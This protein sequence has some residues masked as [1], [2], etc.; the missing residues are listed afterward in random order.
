MR[1]F[2]VIRRL[3]AATLAAAALL[4]WGPTAAA[5]VVVQVMS[6]NNPASAQAEAERLLSFGVPSFQRTENVPDAGLR[7]RVY[8]GPFDTRQEA[9]A[10]AEALKA[11]G[12]VTDYIIREDAGNF[13]APPPPEA[14]PPQ[15]GWSNQ[16]PA[17]A[18]APV[19]AQP[20]AQGDWPAQA[21]GEWPAYPAQPPAQAG[22]QAQGGWPPPAQA[23]APAQGDWPPPAT[24]QAPAQSEW[25][26]YPA[27][28]A[29]QPP[30]Q[31]SA[32]AGGQP[33]PAAIPVVTAEPA[34]SAA[35]PSAWPAPVAAAA[36]ATLTGDM[37]LQGFTILVDLSSSMRRLSPC[38]GGLVKQEAVNSLL[39]KINQRIPN[40]PYTAALRV[41]G[42]KQ[43]WSRRD[44]T[45][46]YF[47]PATY[48]RQGLETA[49]GRLYAADSISP[50]G[51]ALADSEKE[52]ASMKPPMAA[53]MFADFEETT[54]SGA[55]ADKAKNLRRRHG[56]DLKVYAYYVTRQGDAKTLARD[57]AK[58][59]G[60]QAWDVCDLLGSEAAFEGMMNEV[61]G[62][63][64]EPRCADGDSDGVCDD[65]DVCPRT[66]TGAPVDERGCWIA[67]YSQFFDFDK[68]EVKSAFH[69]RLKYA[70]EIMIKNPQIGVVTVA[71]HTDAKGTDAYNLE[72]GRKRAEAVKELLVKF[73]APADK[74]KVE[75]FGKTKPVA[76]NDTAENRAKNRRVEFHVG[77]VPD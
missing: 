68:A 47:G 59:G 35:A 29:A 27:Q 75:S 24:A 44:Y 19:Q 15:T 11:N 3:T 5:Q 37:K 32:Q 77:D 20:P 13:S 67:A 41:F 7:H 36:P 74:L 22:A 45:T 60:G 46:L 10:A 73:G 61:F 18:A 4:A 51:W 70:A 42:Y 52:L 30:A 54:D 26:A 9:A 66:P 40:R 64:E 53:L 63:A 39:R 49:V 62:P 71:G 23:G 65:R 25:P 56:G 33:L 43:A 55:P 17:Q 2:R 57:I 8:L 21:P 12:Q 16:A 76:P 34:A 31:P 1:T 50:F 69:P 14:L 28:P 38:L 48:D 72:L 6:V 58:A